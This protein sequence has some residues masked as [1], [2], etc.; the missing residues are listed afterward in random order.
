MGCWV[1]ILVVM[2]LFPFQSLAQQYNHYT[3]RSFFSIQKQVL[4][5]SFI[6]LEYQHRRQDNPRRAPY[7]ILNNHYQQSF[8]TWLRYEHSDKMELMLSPFAFFRKWPLLATDDDFAAGTRDEVRFTAQAEF[9]QKLTRFR[10]QSRHGYEYRIFYN[11]TASHRGRYRTRAQLQ[12]RIKEELR[13]NFHNEIFLE[14]LPSRPK[15]FF[16]ENR[17]G[18]SIVHHTNWYRFEIGYIYIFNPR[19]N[20]IERDE[21][22]GLVLGFIWKLNPPNKKAQ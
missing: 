18:A 1:K 10:L 9:F 15:S 12:Y 7:Y 11:G 14:T 3:F 2:F 5:Q 13:I 20:L 16:N 8:R 4:P 22:H 21:E 19:D 6:L 17:A